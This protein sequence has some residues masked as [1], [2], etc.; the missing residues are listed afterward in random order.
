MQLYAMFFF[1]A[2]L[3]VLTP[4]PGVVMTLTNTLRYGLRRAAGGILGI[5][6]GTLLVATLSATG[7]GILLATSAVAFTLMKLLGAA[8]LIY[9]GLRLWHSPAL[10]FTPGDGSNG[11]FAHFFRQGVT[12]QITNPKAIFFFLSV[13]PQ[14][15]DLKAGYRHQFILLVMTY[16]S[17]VIVIHGL[18]GLGAGRA[19]RWLI[20]E[21][22]SK[23]LGRI[24]AVMLL[25]F[26][27]ALG[28]AAR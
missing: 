27:V 1:M 16:V 2:T 6:A 13:L 26:G 11:G 7:L 28:S 14:F 19:K 15:I 22:G 24:G 8:Y 9:L 23:V 18:Y 21:R 12:L 25:G 4:G 10:Q 17:L 5:A 3:T 20:S